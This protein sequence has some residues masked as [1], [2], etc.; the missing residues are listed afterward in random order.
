MV[1]TG[2]LSSNT[3]TGLEH[4]ATAECGRF[5]L[6]A[7]PSPAPQDQAVRLHV[8]LSNICRDAFDVQQ[9]D[10]CQSENGI[11][12]EFLSN[13]TLYRLTPNGPGEDVPSCAAKTGAV[14]SVPG[15]GSIAADFVWS[16]RLITHH[17]DRAPNCDLRPA[18]A[19][20]SDR[21]GQGAEFDVR[22]PPPGDATGG[23]LPIVILAADQT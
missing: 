1:A 14:V 2:C 15:H 16:G 6:T 11:I 13:A 7:T 10:S 3:K 17:C 20:P 21:N 23:A 9:T 4:P 19:P 22:L 8:V 12:A 5:A 18:P